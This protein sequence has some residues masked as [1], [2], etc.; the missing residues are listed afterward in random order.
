MRMLTIIIVNAEKTWKSNTS[1]LAT[2][3]RDSGEKD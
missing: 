3:T 2:V 1:Q